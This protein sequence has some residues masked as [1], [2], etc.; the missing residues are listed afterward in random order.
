MNENEF[1][2]FIAKTIL[3]NLIRDFPEETTEALKTIQT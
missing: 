1:K 3:G 2:E